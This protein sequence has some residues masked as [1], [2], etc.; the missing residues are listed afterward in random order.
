[1]EVLR[2]EIKRLHVEE[3]YEYF[4]LKAKCGLHDDRLL[5]ATWKYIYYSLRV[6]YIQ[7][8]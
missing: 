8:N 7:N 2:N 1:M 5:Y 3:C 6:L 4:V